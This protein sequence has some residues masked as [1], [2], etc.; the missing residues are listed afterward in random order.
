MTAAMAMTMPILPA[1]PP[2]ASITSPTAWS[3][4]IFG[5]SAPIRIA[6][7][8]SATN[9]LI[10]QRTISRKTEAVAIER[11]RIGCMDS[12]QHTRLIC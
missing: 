4:G 2:K 7:Q 6:E 12:E 3:S 9:A 1:S 10:F 11:M 8:I 5:E